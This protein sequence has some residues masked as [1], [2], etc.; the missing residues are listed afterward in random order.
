VIGTGN[1]PATSTS[2]VTYAGTAQA[3]SAYTL[4][5]AL[6]ATPAASDLLPEPGPQAGT[7]GP[8]TLI[9]G[10]DFAGIRAPAAPH[11][12]PSA[13]P[14]QVRNAAASICPGLP[15]ANPEP[16]RP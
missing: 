3:D 12:G 10:A 9:I 16:G 15:A 14:V 7:P 8:V 1:A 5:S 6:D 11:P 2:T 4:M 13:A